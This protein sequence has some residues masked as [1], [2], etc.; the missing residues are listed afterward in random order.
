MLYKD[1]TILRT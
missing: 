1:R